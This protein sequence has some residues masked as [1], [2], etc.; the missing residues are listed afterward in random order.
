MVILRRHFLSFTWR[1]IDK[2]ILLVFQ[3]SQIPTINP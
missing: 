1:E 3:V 2:V